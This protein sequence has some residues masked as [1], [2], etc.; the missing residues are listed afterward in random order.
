MSRGKNV[1]V[2]RRLVDALAGVMTKLMPADTTR[3]SLYRSW[4]DASEKVNATDNDWPVSQAIFF[5]NK[6]PTIYEIQYEFQTED[7]VKQRVAHSTTIHIRSTSDQNVVNDTIAFW[8]N[9]HKAVPERF[10]H[11]GSVRI[12]E[13]NPQVLRA[14][15]GLIGSSAARR[16]F[17]W[18]VYTGC[19]PG[20]T[21]G[22]GLVDD[23]A[24]DMF[25][26]KKDG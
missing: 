25:N 13:F 9:R 8:R 10:N 17:E 23:P 18:K 4:F 14:D 7:D 3:Y 11:L 22:S 5:L 19:G 15:G 26:P 6:H 20:V 1:M 24:C 16:V 2:S 21:H 12:F